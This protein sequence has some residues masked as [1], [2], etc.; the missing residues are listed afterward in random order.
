VKRKEFPTKVRVVV[1]KR[2][3]KDCVVYCEGC[4]LPTRDF[5]IDHIIPAALGGAPILE[6]AQLL[7]RCCYSV[8]NPDDTRKAAKAK[9]VEAK[10]LGAG[11]PKKKIKSRGFQQMLK[12]DQT[13]K[14]EP[15]KPLE[16]RALYR[17]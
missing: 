9:R 17:D 6:N 4:G 10:H 3:T 13:P 8:K 16:P 5:Q 11:Q 7:G 14:R 15:K 1:I 2:A 12:H